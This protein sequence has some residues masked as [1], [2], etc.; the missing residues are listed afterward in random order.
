MIF[1]K[2]ITLFY[3][4][5]LQTSKGKNVSTKQK[6]PSHDDVKLRKMDTEVNTI[7][8]CAGLIIIFGNV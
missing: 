8:L 7:Y 2:K 4:C 6:A 3:I 5:V 1:K